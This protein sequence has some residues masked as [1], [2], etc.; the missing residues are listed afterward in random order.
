MLLKSTLKWHN[1]KL[2]CTYD[3]STYQ[4][5]NIIDCEKL[6]PYNYYIFPGDSLIKDR[7]CSLT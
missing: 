5:T 4:R 3:N 1:S 6:F 2:L 7:F